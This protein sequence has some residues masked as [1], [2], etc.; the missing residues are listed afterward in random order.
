M[1]TSGRAS[2][3]SSKKLTTA[4]VLI[5]GVVTGTNA[6]EAK[7]YYSSSQSYSWV[8]ESSS[9]DIQAVSTQD[10]VKVVLATY[11]L[12][13]KDFEPIL[14]V[15]R[16]NIYNWKKGLNEPNPTQYEKIKTLYDISKVLTK[17]SSKIGRL[18]KTFSYGELSFIERL[19]ATRLDYAEIAKHHSLLV[20]K[21]EAQQNAYD[22]MNKKDQVDSEDF[23][24]SMEGTV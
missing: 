23:Y 21:V 1:D 22:N 10:M 3:F 24:V 19:S 15:G 13:V 20:S 12:A 17:P 16:A 14:G 11:G 2:R 9:Q 5:W 6:S 8:V 18:A 4:T 7:D